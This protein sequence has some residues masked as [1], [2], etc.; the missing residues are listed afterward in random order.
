MIDLIG[1]PLF[2]AAAQT[3]IGAIAGYSIDKIIDIFYKENSFDGAL[4]FW[5]RGV[6]QKSIQEG[7]RLIFD[8]LISPYLQLFLRE[9]L[10]Q[11]VGFDAY[12]FKK[13]FQKTLSKKHSRGSSGVFLDRYDDY[14]ILQ[15]Y[16]LIFSHSAHMLLVTW[17]HA[18]NFLVIVDADKQEIPFVVLRLQRKHP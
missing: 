5:Q 13:V 4:D 16:F 8:G 10:R 12:I 9:I 6:R 11:G 18:R 1:K 15:L 2:E 7:D 14:L 3:F 17:I